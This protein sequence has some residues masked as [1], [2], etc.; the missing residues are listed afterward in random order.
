MITFDHDK[1]THET[2]GKSSLSYS[3]LID[4]MKSCSQSMVC[5]L[6]HGLVVSTRS[7]VG[8]AASAF[9]GGHSWRLKENL[10]LQLKLFLLELDQFE[11]SVQ[12]KEAAVSALEWG[13][14]DLV[15]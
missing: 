8:S 2:F 3:P 13:F 11:A 14:E 6:H 9:S 4:G 7:W 10:Q 12:M 1:K 5:S 15:D